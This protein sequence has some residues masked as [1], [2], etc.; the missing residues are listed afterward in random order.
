MS[1]RHAALSGNESPLMDHTL[2]IECDPARF[3]VSKLFDLFERRAPVWCVC[4]CVHNFLF[5]STHPIFFY[6]SCF[7]L[8]ISQL[9]S[10]LMNILIQFGQVLKFGRRENKK[11]GLQK[12]KNKEGLAQ[13]PYLHK[14]LPRSAISSNHSL[15]GRLRLDTIIAGV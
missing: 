9:N 14:Y 1:L 8:G 15:S 3:G 13:F 11:F 2:A 10:I 7:M 5:K 12:Q 4:F 6:H